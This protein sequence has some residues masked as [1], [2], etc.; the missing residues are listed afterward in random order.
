MEG[1]SRRSIQTRTFILEHTLLKKKFDCLMATYRLHKPTTLSDACWKDTFGLSYVE[2]SMV[3]NFF[4][5]FINVNWSYL[6][7]DN[8]EYWKDKLASCAEAIRKKCN[9]CFKQENT[10]KHFDLLAPSFEV[11]IQNGPR[12]LLDEAIIN[13]EI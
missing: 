2:V 5:V 6:L 10:G 12:R 4:V 3:F 9:N 11:W 1:G 13:D 8:M 7:L